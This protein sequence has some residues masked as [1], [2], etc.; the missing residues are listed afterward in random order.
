[1]K[2]R[3]WCVTEKRFASQTVLEVVRAW[4]RNARASVAAIERLH[5]FHKASFHGKTGRSLE[6]GILRAYL[7]RWM[8]AHTDR[9]HP[10]FT[11]QRS[12]VHP[13]P[14]CIF[15]STPP[16]RSECTGARARARSHSV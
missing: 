15:G 11:K 9:G 8:R 13:L 5:A 6:A 4:G 2:L 16:A 10:D 7:R 14:S 12:L 3:D 1:M